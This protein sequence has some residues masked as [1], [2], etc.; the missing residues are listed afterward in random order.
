MTSAKIRGCGLVSHELR[1]KSHMK[2]IS[3]AEV[4]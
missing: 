4:L 3:L 2:I 1:A